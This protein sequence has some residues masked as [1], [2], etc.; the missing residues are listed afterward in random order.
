[1]AFLPLL[2]LAAASQQVVATEAPDWDALFDRDAGWT[3][4]DGIYSIPL[5]SN[6]QQGSAALTKTLFVFSDTFIGDVDAQGR[7]LPGTTIVNNTLGLLQESTLPDP[8]NM[9]FY[10]GSDKGAPAAA[11]VPTTP[12]AL[13]GEFYWMKDGIAIGDQVHLFG[14][15]FESIVARKGVAMITLDTTSPNP[16]ASATQVE[17]PLFAPETLDHDEITFGGGFLDNSVEAGAPFPD[18]YVYCYGVEELRSTKKAVVARVPRT[19]FTDFT[20]WT[21]WDG[22]TWSTDIHDSEPIAGRVSTEMSVTP[23]PTGKFLMV[24]MLDTLGGKVAYRIGDSPEGPWGPFEEVYTVPIPPGL[25]DVYS[26]HAKAHPGLSAPGELLVSYNVNTLDF[27]QHFDI[28]D[29]Y[30]PRF[31]R[32]TL[33]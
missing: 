28:A 2:L 32:L 14:A 17:V 25:P 18:G 15:R 4:A 10:W 22:A 23:L 12:S 21:F 1:M 33:Q 19:Q 9:D 11:F 31:I 30:R 20:A 6:D 3:G 27:L 8:A 16:I 24:F 13:P 26:Y 7:R 5:N 29:I